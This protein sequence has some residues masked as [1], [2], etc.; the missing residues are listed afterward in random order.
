MCFVAAWTLLSDADPSGFSDGSFVRHVPLI[1]ALVQAVVGLIVSAYGVRS[2]RRARASVTWP[3]A[4]GKITASEVITDG[5]AAR[6]PKIRYEYLVN[7]Q[8]FT[9]DRLKV[10]HKNFAMTGN[11]AQTA[12]ERYPAGARVRV[13]FNPDK[14]TQS[15]LEPGVNPAAYVGM[16]IGLA[17]LVGAMIEYFVVGA[18]FK[19]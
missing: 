6:L 4:E 5:E 15:A 16:I 18:V 17:L 19:P 1:V 14:P 10:G 13:F 11:L 9:G 3:G 12:V 2:F 7:G 8:P